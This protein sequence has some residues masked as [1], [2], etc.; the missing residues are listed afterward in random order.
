MLSFTLGSC[1]LSLTNL[2]SLS[3]PPPP[4]TTD[5]YHEHGLTP[6][7]RWTWTLWH[8]VHDN[9]K[10]KQKHYQPNQ[11]II[12]V[13]LSCPHVLPALFLITYIAV[14]PHCSHHLVF[15]STLP[16]SLAQQVRTW[17]WM[18]SGIV[19]RACGRL[20][21]NKSSSAQRQSGTVRTGKVSVRRL[22]QVQWTGPLWVMWWWGRAQQQSN[23]RRRRRWSSRIPID[24]VRAQR[25]RENAEFVNN[26]K[27]DRLL[28]EEAVPEHRSSRRR[29]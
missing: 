4:S 8:V 16:S 24:D 14:C 27:S 25:C 18:T 20:H 13:F 21:D 15:L 7:G 5:W 22:M 19:V 9:K 26:R 1:Q 12:I 29:I 17:W 11:I 3:R 6:S 28:A 2:L 10:H 23:R